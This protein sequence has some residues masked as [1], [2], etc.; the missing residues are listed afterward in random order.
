MFWRGHEAMEFARTCSSRSFDSRRLGQPRSRSRG[1]SR[2]V[3]ASN[4]RRAVGRMI[5][6]Q[7]EC[8]FP[9][10]KN[11]V[12]LAITVVVGELQ[13]PELHLQQRGTMVSSETLGS[14]APKPR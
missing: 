6:R 1:E 2:S 5:R 13:P 3:V 12:M 4:S 11:H 9:K 14:S 10:D 8:S 7:R